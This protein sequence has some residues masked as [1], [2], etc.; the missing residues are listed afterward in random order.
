MKT[1]GPT[2][3]LLYR[4][5]A[6]AA[7]GAGSLGVLLPLLPTTPFLLVALWAS[8]RGAPE[9][10]AKIRHHPRFAPTLADWESERAVSTRAKISACAF[11]AA[12]W[13][14]MLAMDVHRFVLIGLALLFTIVAGYLVSR[15][16]PSGPAC[17]E[18]GSA[19]G[20]GTGEEQDHQCRRADEDP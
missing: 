1:P 12:S 5:L 18:A 17:V 11:M 14:I 8:A 16:A 6:V 15:P 3:R 19:N 2:A 10:Y 9:W 4:A 7:V 20:N 13:L